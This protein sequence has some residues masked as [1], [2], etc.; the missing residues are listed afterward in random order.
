MHFVIDSIWVHQERAVGGLF[1]SLFQPLQIIRIRVRNS[2][3]KILNHGIQIGQM[4]R[5]F[6]HVLIPLA[7]RHRHLSLTH[8][9]ADHRIAAVQLFLHGFQDFV[10]IFF[11]AAKTSGTKQKHL[12]SPQLLQKVRRAFI[13]FSLIRPETHIKGV[14]FH[15]GRVR[16]AEIAAVLLRE[17]SEQVIEKL[18]LLTDAEFAELE[19]PL[20]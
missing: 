10:K 8:E 3:V 2:L 7:Y 4:N 1:Y 14:R 16:D 20:D 11:A 19:F 15:G 13:R 12:L 18:K 17:L 6:F 5:L 9:A